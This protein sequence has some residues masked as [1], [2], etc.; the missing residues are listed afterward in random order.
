MI[1]FLKEKIANLFKVSSVKTVDDT[2][3]FQTAVVQ[4]SGK[5]QKT[6]SVAPY[7]FSSNAPAGSTGVTWTQGGLESSLI[8]ILD[9]PEL[10]P[11]N[12]LPGEVAIFN[13]VTGDILKFEAVSIVSLLTELFNIIGDVSIDGD[14]TNTG[15]IT[16][17][18]DITATNLL[19]ALISLTKHTH[20]VS[21]V[22]SPTGPPLP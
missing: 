2:G 19:S 17:S 12:L 1:Q 9:N 20:N 4:Y 7:G 21:A 3:N 16:S 11:K 13:G 18:G 15:S 10:R 8:S 5:T 14:I 6:W 22:G